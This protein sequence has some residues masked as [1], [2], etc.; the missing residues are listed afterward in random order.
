[1]IDEAEARRR[2]QRL[3]E[4]QST[5]VLATTDEEG[6]HAAPL[7][8]LPG[9]DAT[10]LWLSSPRSRHAMASGEVAVA[11]HAPTFRWEAIRGAQLRGRVEVVA[12]GTEREGLLA[13]YRARFALEDSFEQAIARSCLYRFV[14]SWA[15]YL[16]NALGF[17]G[18]VEIHHALKR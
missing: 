3:I 6:A 11:I 5:L 17:P 18:K 2:L 7:F 1:M 8:Y 16:D 14:P 9:P 12:A 15:R 10:L 13:A 4:E